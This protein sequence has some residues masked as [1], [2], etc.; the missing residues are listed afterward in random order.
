MAV[1]A[2]TVSA[3]A[4]VAAIMI[5]IM[6][7]PMQVV[8]TRR[9][10]EMVPMSVDLG[11]VPIV[12][13]CVMVIVVSTVASTPVIATGLVAMTTVLTMPDIDVDTATSEVNAKRAG[14]FDAGSPQSC[15][16]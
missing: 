7:A 15:Q 2:V 1:A 10:V 11:W 14:R 4:S 3:V 12:V 8:M 6:A 16:S 13:A 9:D 5:I